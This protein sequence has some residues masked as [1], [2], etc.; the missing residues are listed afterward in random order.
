MELLVGAGNSRTKKI[1]LS[2]YP[3]EWTELIT[4]DIDPSTEPRVVHD[5][6]LLPLPFGDSMFD[7]V[8]AYEVLE[9]TG[10]QGDWRFFFNQFYEFWRILKPGGLMCGTVPLWDSPWAWGDPGHTRVLPRESFYFL[11]QALYANEVGKTSLTDYRGWWKGDFE[12]LSF[13][14]YEHSLGFVMKAIK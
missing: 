2:G 9:H 1:R 6:N 8:H 13:N 11:S 5:L 3:Q 14:D 10:T 7:E 12:L 4:L